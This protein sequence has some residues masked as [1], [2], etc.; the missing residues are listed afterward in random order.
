MPN[1]CC[2]QE[3]ERERAVQYLDYSNCCTMLHVLRLISARTACSSAEVLIV[4][5]GIEE[6]LQ[7]EKKDIIVWQSREPFKDGKCG[8]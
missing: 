6:L 3:R 7:I 2:L 8:I 4:H 5:L 1:G